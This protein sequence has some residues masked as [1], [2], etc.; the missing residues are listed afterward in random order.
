ML[1]PL[2]FVGI[3]M[4]TCRPWSYGFSHLL[5]SAIVS[6]KEGDELGYRFAVH[7]GRSRCLR[8][9]VFDVI[10]LERGRERASPS[11]MRCRLI[12]DLAQ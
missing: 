7:P 5:R 12:R 2:P 10:F 9:V 3:A 8:N 1:R 11:A 6:V 4:V